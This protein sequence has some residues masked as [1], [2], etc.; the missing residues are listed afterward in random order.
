M[1]HGGGEGGELRV[2]LVKFKALTLSAN[3]HLHL[4]SWQNAWL[5]QKAKCERGR[6]RGAGRAASS[7]PAPCLSLCFFL[8]LYFSLLGLPPLFSLL[9]F[10]I[11]DCPLASHPFSSSTLPSASH[12]FL[13]SHPFLASTFS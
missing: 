5:N 9:F 2:A 11:L 13:T 12:P 4:K 6:A 1:L 7:G 3:S 8:S 10:L